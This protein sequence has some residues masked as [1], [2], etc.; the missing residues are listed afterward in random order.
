M[1]NQI[2]LVGLGGFFGAIARYGVYTLCTRLDILTAT[3]FPLATLT[4][5]VLGCFAAGSLLGQFK[6]HPLFETLLPLCLVGFLGAF[7]T[8]SAFGV[9]T[10]Q[11]LK[12][13]STPLALVNITLNLMLCLMAVAMGLWIFKAA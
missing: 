12:E 3:R 4:V 11:L 7:T 8:F 6:N 10:I 5:N 2:L 13:G 1:I 9:E